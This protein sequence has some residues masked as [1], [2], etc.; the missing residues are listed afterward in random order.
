MARPLEYPRELRERAVRMV[1]ESKAHH[2]S[3]YEAIR[4]IAMKLGLTSPVFR[5]ITPRHPHRLNL[6]ASMGRVEPCLLTTPSRRAGLRSRSP[7]SAPR[8]GHQGASPC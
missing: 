3:E 6:R 2:E 5:D 4:S 1:W 7:R 8:S